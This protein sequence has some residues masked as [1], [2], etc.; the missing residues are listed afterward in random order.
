MI[1]LHTSG[2]FDAHV[3]DPLR[4]DLDKTEPQ[5]GKFLRD[6]VMDDGVTGRKHR[7]FEASEAALSFEQLHPIEVSRGSM[8]TNRQIR[9][10]RR[11]VKRKE[12]RMAEALVV[13][14]ATAEDAASP[15]GL[16]EPDF[17]DGTCHVDHWNHGDPAQ[18]P[19]SFV[20]DIN[21]PLIVTSADRPLDF[22][23]GGQWAKKQRRIKNL[24]VDFKLVHVLETAFNIAHL[25]N[26]LGQTVVDIDTAVKHPSVD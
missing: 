16:G 25:P 24:N 4:P 15:I 9:R 11:F 12:E 7:D 26:R 21:Q 8:N 10:F 2:Q 5:L 6:A 20:T 1:S 14:Q 13:D 3:R 17:F 18:P 22:G 19:F 23:F